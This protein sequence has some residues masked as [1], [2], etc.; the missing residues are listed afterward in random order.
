MD[1]RLRNFTLK[2][3]IAEYWGTRSATFDEQ[4]GHGIR[5]QA[6][7]EA[8]AALFR[9]HLP[10]G[11]RDVLELASGTGE[12]TR[13]LRAMGLGVTGLDLAEPMIRRARMKH[14]DA[15][16]AVRFLHGDAEHTLLPP[17]SFDAVV[18]RH[19]VWTLPDPARAMRDWRRVLRPGGRVV[20][21]D[22]DWGCALAWPPACAA[23]W[24]HCGTGWMAPPGPGTRM[25]TRRSCG[26]CRSATGCAMP[27]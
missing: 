26:S 2:D 3:Q 8:W 27:T 6:E 16:A 23:G 18:C 13:V 20:I 12:V 24:W 5:S 15:G 9:A 11:A 1:G 19:L 4:P 7:I 22:G 25:R 10:D 17:A 14:A 21:V